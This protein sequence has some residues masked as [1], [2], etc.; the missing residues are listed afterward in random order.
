MA[1]PVL[2]AREVKRLLAVQK[3]RMM[4]TPAEERF[5]KITRLA[6][7]MFNV[8]LAVIDLIGETRIWL[9]S[10]QG[11]DAV[12]AARETSFCQFAILNDDICYIPDTHEDPRL[13]GNPNAH[14]GDQSV[15][16]YAGFPLQFD[17]E[18]VGVL[19]IAG[20]VPR[21]MSD[22]DMASLRDL[23]SLAEHEINVAKLTENQRDLAA[24]NE[25][26]E[27]KAL[28]DDLTRIWNRG[29]IHE[30]A[31]R[32]METAT[33]T[34]EPCA[35]LSLDIDHFKAIND[36]YG[37]PAG[38]EVLRQVSARLRGA[39]RPTDAVGRVG[40][41][42]FLIVLPACD[43][44]GA[45]TAGERV[46]KAISAKPI[47]FSGGS[48]QVTVSIGVASSAEAPTSEVML[49]IADEALYRA[50]RGGRDRVA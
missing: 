1:A 18:N 19:C 30:I 43:H 29:A 17:G 34:D 21:V 8:P 11:M 27:Q 48:L 45:A 35:I 25:H 47:S 10:V 33:T 49:R 44:D 46:R 26:L 15:R 14:A 6:K 28:V 12:V 4:G 2:P 9:K 24:E 32:E 5:D 38:D 50:K 39:L 3:L 42:E 20:F 40:G 23:A 7:R 16:F 36:G 22:D 31:Q 41:E 13:V 37:H